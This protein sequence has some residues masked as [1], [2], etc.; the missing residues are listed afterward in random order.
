MISVINRSVDLLEQN[1]ADEIPDVIFSALEVGTKPKM[2]GEDFYCTPPELLPEVF[3]EVLRV[4]GI[5]LLLGD[6]YAGWQWDDGSGIYQCELEFCDMD[7]DY[8]DPAG[9]VAIRPLG[10]GKCALIVVICTRWADGF[11]PSNLI[12]H[13]MQEAKRYLDTLL[14]VDT[15]EIPFE[16]R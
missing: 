11:D 1:K 5:G 3:P 9:Y 10:H 2:A 4:Q 7:A 6:K 13:T 8:L 14:A 15:P 16:T 12:F